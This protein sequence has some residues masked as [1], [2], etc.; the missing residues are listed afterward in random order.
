MEKLETYAF[1]PLMKRI[2][3]QALFIV[4]KIHVVQTVTFKQKTVDKER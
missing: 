4:F 2:M 3:Q 1:C